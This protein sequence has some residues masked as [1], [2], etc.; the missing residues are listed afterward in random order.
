MT[1]STNTVWLNAAYKVMTFGASLSA[2]LATE[3]VYHSLPYFLTVT[4]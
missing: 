2:Q 3:A 1:V 4:E